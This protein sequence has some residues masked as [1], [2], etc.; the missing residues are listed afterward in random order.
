[1]RVLL[2]SILTISAI[3]FFQKRSDGQSNSNSK[4]ISHEIWNSL[5]S[6]HVNSKGDV[7]YY[8]F[9]EDSIKFNEYIDLL[10]SNH[11]NEN[12]WNYNERKAYWINA[13]NAFTVQLIIR[14][15]PVES[16][17]DLGGKIYK[18]N[19]PWDQRFIF[20]EGIDYDLN[21]IEH[22]I[23]RK[24][25]T[26]PRIHFAVNCASISCPKLRNE[27]FQA[28]ELDSQLDDASTGFINNQSKNK[29]SKDKIEISKIFKWFK[30]DFT[31]ESDL[32]TFLNQ[33]SEVKID[34]HAQ[35]DHLDYNWNLNE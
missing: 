6:E 14:N 35:I 34:P 19:T 10:S 8:G 9:I 2:L 18:V 22:D 27:S 7:N 5:L 11:P 32:I 13:Y 25:Y 33:Y 1:M 23:L 30:S 29:I 24:H 28:E 17:K 31:E 3:F 16:I 21:N 4:P 15:Y 26:D 12:N 20:I